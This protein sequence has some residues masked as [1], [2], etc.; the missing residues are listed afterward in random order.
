MLVIRQHDETAFEPL[1]TALQFAPIMGIQ[2]VPSA[3][4]AKLMVVGNFYDSETA[5]G[6][7]DAFSGALLTF[8]EDGLAEHIQTLNV[9]GDARS[10]VSLT[11]NENKQ[12]FLVGRNKGDLMLCEQRDPP[13]GYFAQLQ[14]Q[15]FY[16]TIR[17]NDERMYR[18]EFYYGA[19][20]LSQSSRR[21]FV[22]ATAEEVIIYSF[23]GESRVWNPTFNAKELSE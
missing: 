5:L 3:N 10:L 8:D 20:Y 7:Y 19:G 21:L 11:L 2:A 12:F 16:A 1:P 17:M 4:A 18:E 23:S 9:P 13:K 22:P 6:P 15:D 14:P